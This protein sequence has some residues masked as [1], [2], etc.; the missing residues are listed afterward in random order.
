MLLRRCGHLRSHVIAS[1]V[2]GMMLSNLLRL[3][4]PT[5]SLISALQRASAAASIVRARTGSKLLTVRSMGEPPED[6]RDI[7]LWRR[8]GP[9]V[10]FVHL[11]DR[12]ANSSMLG[13]SL[14]PAFDD[15]RSR[16]PMGT[17]PSA[18]GIVTDGRVFAF[19]QAYPD[20]LSPRWLADHEAGINRAT[21]LPTSLHAGNPLWAASELQ[22]HPL[23]VLLGGFE[24]HALSVH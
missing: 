1:R 24:A 16:W 11:A 17:V 15:L 21:E 23:S 2:P 19:N 3:P 7:Y 5:R 12:D 18:L 9:D 8:Q 10:T 14:R 20:G 4:H 6:Q 22:L 13:L